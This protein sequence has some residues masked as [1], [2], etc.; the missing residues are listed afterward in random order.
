[1][2]DFRR[3][4]VWARA[5]ALALAIRRATRGFPRTGYS[6]LKSQLSRAADSI[7]SNIVEGCAAATRKEF[8]RY[9]DISLKSTSEVEYRLQLARDEAVLPDTAWLKLAGE[10]VEIRKM[11]YTLRRVVL[12]ADKAS[13]DR[14]GSPP[15]PELDHRE[16]TEN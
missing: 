5:H 4:E 12:A 7:A 3:L 2:Q 10:T 9:L 13:R 6:D 8:A 11:V 16:D 1:M 15:A 14:G